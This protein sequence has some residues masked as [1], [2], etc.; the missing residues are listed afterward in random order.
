MDFLSEE[1]MVP[2]NG[3]VNLQECVEI[4][5]VRMEQPTA[6]SNINYEMITKNSVYTEVKGVNM[7]EAIYEEVYDADGVRYRLCYEMDEPD[8]LMF[9]TAEIY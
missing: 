8:E 1:S 4:E 6:F 5:K 7:A 2:E 3:A 9:V